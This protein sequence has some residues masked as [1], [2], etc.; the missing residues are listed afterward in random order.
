MVTLKIA[1]PPEPDPD[2]AGFTII[3]S[4]EK[5][6]ACIVI[7]NADRL[8]PDDARRYLKAVEVAISER[9]VPQDQR[10]ISQVKVVRFL[11]EK[12]VRMAGSNL[13]THVNGLC[14]CQ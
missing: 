11:R 9:V 2:L 13:S 3:P 14:S 1:E 10:T 12:G 7:R 4:A 6:R 8:T 5:I